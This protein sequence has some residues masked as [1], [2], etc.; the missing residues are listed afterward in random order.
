M[1]FYFD[2]AATTFPKPECVY[3]FMDSFFRKHG[4]NAGRGQYKLAAESSKIIFE[5]R[6]F[7]Q[8]I[9]CSPNKDVIF[10][11]SAT[12]A[13][14]VVIQGLLADEKKRTVYIS[15]FEHNSVTRVLHHFE[16]RGKI[17][18]RQLFVSPDF[19][20]DIEKIN[21]Q[22]AELPPDI[23]I[24]S[25]ASNVIGLVSPVLEIFAAAKKYGALTVTDMAQTAG[26]VPLD[27]ASDL[28]DFAVFAGHKTLYGPFG[29]GG[30]A[31]SRN[32]A[33]EPVLFGGTG[34]DSANQ[35]MPENIPGR[36]E[37]GSQNICAVAGLHA[38]A[39]WFLQNQDEIRAAEEKNHRRLLEILRQYDF[40][41][42]AGPADRFSEKTKC[43][44]VVSTVFDGY[45]AEDIGNVFD[46]MEIAVRTGLQCSPL[47]HK[48]LGTFPAG[49]VRFSV[50]YFTGEEDFCALE[51]AM[52]YIEEN[53]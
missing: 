16:K 50:G 51:K 45:A 44:G 42:I 22:F 47:A 26:L 17:C 53:R 24:L 23:V 27:V 40:V 7:I 20:Y 39:Q 13:L 9:L 43:I 14:N 46:E 33:L 52:G 28:V 37:M 41:K 5:T 49:T 4:G 30:F 29:I 34:V 3:A 12:V 48:F 15:P 11:P 1:S 25:H 2:N 38:A 35:E 19:E 32:V 10:A 18:V 8:K 36:Y 6:G 31:K 21:A